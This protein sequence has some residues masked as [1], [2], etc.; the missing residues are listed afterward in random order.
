ML[1][2]WAG[3][4]ILP[5][6]LNLPRFLVGLVFLDHYLCVVCFSDYCL[7]FCRLSL[8]H[9]IVCL[10]V[11]WFPLWYLQQSIF[12]KDSKSDLLNVRINIYLR[13]DITEI[14]L[15]LTALIT[16][17]PNPYYLPVGWGAVICIVVFG[18]F[19]CALTTGTPSASFSW[20]CWR[21]SGT[22]S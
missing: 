1:C 21:L 8:G 20:F 3:I 11:L 19:N 6:H 9:F 7:S 16:V 10:N 15:K 14:L 22:R 5:E 2:K 4:P 17:N 12:Y 18:S 13:H